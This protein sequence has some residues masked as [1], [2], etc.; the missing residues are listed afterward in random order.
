MLFRT[1]SQEAALLAACPLIPVA[2]KQTWVMLRLA[3]LYKVRGNLVPEHLALLAAL[4]DKLQHPT[5]I[6]FMCSVQN[7]QLHLDKVI[8]LSDLRHSKQLS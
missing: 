7:G 6:A 3:L 5:R 2:I 4:Y 1:D 8:C